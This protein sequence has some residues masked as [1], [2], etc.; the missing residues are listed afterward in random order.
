MQ[1]FASNQ[2]Y[3]LKNKI[4]KKVLKFIGVAAGVLLLIG[5]TGYLV[6]FYNSEEHI[7]KLKASEVY[8]PEKGNS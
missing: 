7:L 3:L 2:T 1:E 5:I 8:S 4:M 6:W